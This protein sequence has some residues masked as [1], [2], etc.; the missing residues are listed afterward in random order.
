MA[1][2]VLAA[3]VLAFAGGCLARLTLR[4]DGYGCERDSDCAGLR[5][6]SGLCASYPEGDGGLAD[7]GSRPGPTN[8]GVPPG[9]VLTPA[10]S[11]SIT[12]NGSV[13]DGL[14]IQGCLRVYANNVTVR[15]SRI[16]GNCTLGIEIVEPAQN[17]LLEDV[18]IDGSPNSPFQSAAVASGNFIARRLDLHGFSHAARLTG[19]AELHDSY[20]HDMRGDDDVVQM[21][22]GANVLIQNNR[23]EHAMKNKGVITLESD[24]GATTNVRV[25]D[26]YLNGGNP[27]VYVGEKNGFPIRA[28]HIEGNR[29]GRDFVGAPVRLGPGEIFWVNNVFDDT[30][31]LITP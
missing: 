24:F 18:E 28:V 10:G 12:A 26:N 15:R 8:T 6:V 2:W 11:M 31:E 3:C 5:C 9:T 25:L 22:S 19:D 29:F 20:V 21:L 4:P 13:L 27:T 7:A 23:F 14:D 1:K 30:G 17:L 16:R